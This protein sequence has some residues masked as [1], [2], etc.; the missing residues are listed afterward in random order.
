MAFLIR[1]VGIALLLSGAIA[2]ADEV[3]EGDALPRMTLADRNGE[4]V[5]IRGD[6]A[7]VVIVEFWASWCL[8]C[9]KTVPAIVALAAEQPSR[10]RLFAVSIDRDDEKAA[11][12]VREYLPTLPASVTLLRDPE[13]SAM[14]RFGPQ[15]MPAVYAAEDGIVRL[16]VSGAR[17]DLEDLVRQFVAQSTP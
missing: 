17:S 5:E 10:V 15:G 2:R 14:A 3:G 8:P 12:F 1:V 16:A 13:A 6:A 4:D 7:P 11:Q 9:R